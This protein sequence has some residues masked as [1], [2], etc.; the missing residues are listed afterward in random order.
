MKENI[1]K[2]L[3][4]NLLLLKN[5]LQATSHKGI[6][7]FRVSH[8]NSQNRKEWGDKV[9]RWKTKK[10]DIHNDPLELKWL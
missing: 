3:N 8:K 9:P 7:L 10:V 2:I 5:E 6:Y 1:G 4:K